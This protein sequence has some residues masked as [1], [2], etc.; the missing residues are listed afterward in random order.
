MLTYRKRRDVMLKK[1]S[2]LSIYNNLCE[3]VYRNRLVEI[4]K[5]GRPCQIPKYK[6]ICFI[7]LWKTYGEGLEKMELDSELYLGKH[8]DHS[9][10]AYHYSRLD[11]QVIE[12]ITWHYERLCIKILEQDIIF[13][14]F[15]STAI[16][17]SVREERLRQGTRNKQKITQ[18][19]HTTLGYD[20]P[21]QLV[22]V[23]S[24][25]ASDHHTSDSQGALK[26]MEGKDWKG[27]DFG[28]SAYET[29]DLINATLDSGRI[30]IYK[31]TKKTVRKKTS[32]KAKF[33]KKFDG[34]LKRLY[35]E[36]RGLGE[37][38]YGAAT[39]AGLMLSNCR[40]IENQH[41]DALIIGLRQNLLTYL[42][43]EALIIII[44]KTLEKG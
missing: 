39:R 24:M 42:R 23:E 40:L 5:R 17:T 31:P 29:Y 9:S 41:K 26:M 19:F 43:L 11:S 35:K 13:H 15:D 25:L 4:S 16:S 12:K 7:L 28:D 8:Y 3:V 18:K 27:Y 44:R 6:L 21:N 22:I 10:F 32:N 2:T 37:V 36:I 20:P 33:R 30:P 14:I 1:H 38:L 34:N